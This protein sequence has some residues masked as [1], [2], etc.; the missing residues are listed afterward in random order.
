MTAEDR[1]PTVDRRRLLR[2]GSLLGVVGLAGCS[3]GGDGSSDET[4]TGGSTDETPDETTGGGGTSADPGGLSVVDSD[5][6]DVADTR[7]VVLTAT[8]ENDGSSAASGVLV[9]EVEI[10]GIVN[11]QWREV[12]VP[13]GEQTQ[14]YL[15]VETNHGGGVT[16]FTHD[17]TLQDEPPADVDAPTDADYLAVWDVESES[18]SG[19]SSILVTPTVR[20][21]GAE[22]RS[23][24]LVGKITSDSFAGPVI[25]ERN[26]SVPGESRKTVEVSLD[27]ESQDGVFVYT[28][29]AWVE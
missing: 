12:S 1:S 10:D 20:N 18:V 21:V 24:T 26:V 3:S 5:S 27:Y 22:P 15:K 16:V 25:E 23:A 6:A 4:P 17:V 29:S 19:E 28:S 13:A 11:R 9:G 8:V 14:V 2:T 7:A